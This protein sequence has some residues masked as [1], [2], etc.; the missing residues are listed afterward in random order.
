[1]GRSGA[2]NS[3]TEAH[4]LHVLGTVLKQGTL[5]SP[6]DS[7]SEGEGGAF[8]ESLGAVR[9]GRGGLG[10]KDTGR[11][12][13]PGAQ[14]IREK[15]ETRVT[16]ASPPAMCSLLARDGNIV[17]PTRRERGSRGDGPEGLQV[18]GLLLPGEW[19]S[20]GGGARSHP[21][22]PR[23]GPGAT[24]RPWPRM[25]WGQLSFHSVGGRDNVRGYRGSWQRLGAF[26][27]LPACM[28]P[29]GRRGAGV[30]TMPTLR[31]A[32]SWDSEA[33]GLLCGHSCHVRGES[34]RGALEASP[35]R[36]G[37]RPGRRG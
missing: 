23:K 24:F 20:G 11:R 4:G 31:G 36:P 14:C 8:V 3:I 12:Y 7:T 28:W 26:W 22:P 9:T 10:R 2:E 37:S 17:A 6:A 5:V 16:G 15:A 33:G 19:L 29:W 34:S 21:L 27:K 35:R 30:P 13:P 32:G 25:G 18:W 1:M